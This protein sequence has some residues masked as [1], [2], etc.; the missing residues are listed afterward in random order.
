MYT[1]LCVCT[2]IYIYTLVVDVYALSIWSTSTS[3]S[4]GEHIYVPLLET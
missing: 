2:H 3:L 4:S 1:M